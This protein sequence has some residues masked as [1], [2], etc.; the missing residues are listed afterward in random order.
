MTLKHLW[1]SVEVVSPYSAPQQ[2]W[3]T[4]APEHQGGLW[5]VVSGILDRVPAQA[6][7]QPYRARLVAGWVLK[8]EIV[9]KVR[10]CKSKEAM[11]G[12]V[13]VSQ[14]RWE[15]W[16]VRRSRYLKDRWGK[17]ALGIW[18]ASLYNDSIRWSQIILGQKHVGNLSQTSRRRLRIYGNWC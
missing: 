9:N 16:W 4:H 12:E 18:S 7:L 2:E 1:A 5:G 14:G 11:L 13:E 10:W 17:C 8:L 15:K 3:V 6:P